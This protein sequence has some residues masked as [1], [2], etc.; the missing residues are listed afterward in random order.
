MS[1]ARRLAATD[2]RRFVGAPDQQMAGRMLAVEGLHQPPHLIAVPDVAALELRKQNLVAADLIQQILGRLHLVHRTLS[3]QASSLLSRCRHAT[4]R[5]R[6]S[7]CST[8]TSGR[9]RSVAYSIN[10][11]V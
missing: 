3:C 7:A 5:R 8:A 4:A 6:L 11:D 9:Q 2:Q 10:R 1:V